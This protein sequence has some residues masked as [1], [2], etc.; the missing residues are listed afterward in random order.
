MDYINRKLERT[1]HEAAQYFPVIAVTGPRQS[2]KSTLLGHLF[3]E[4]VKFS[5]KDVNVRSFAESDPVAFLNQTDKA[6]FIDEVQKVPMLFEYIQG[7]VDNHPDR[8]FLLSG[9][10]NFEL[11]KSLSESL[12]GRAGIYELMPM[13]YEE[14]SSYQNGK[15]L[16][17]FLYDGLFPA[18]CAGK[19]ISRLFYP[20]YVKTYIEKDI[21]DLLHIK[22][23]M[24]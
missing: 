1:L 20:A 24:L 15:D 2:G 22:D 10:S 19:N 17:T 4:A 23:S 7:I 14:I 11:M 6:I 9:S 21:R 13:S 16:N 12:A 18:I 5:M 8:K 3:P